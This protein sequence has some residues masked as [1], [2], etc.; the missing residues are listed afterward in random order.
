MVLYKLKSYF[1]KFLNF[2]IIIEKALYTS[3]YLY[4]YIGCIIMEQVYD[5]KWYNELVSDCRE[6]QKE[7]DKSKLSILYL[8]YSMGKRILKDYHRFESYEGGKSQAN[9]AIDLGYKSNATISDMI[10][11][12][13][14][15]DKEFDCEVNKFIDSVNKVP[16]WHE[17]THNLLP[18]EPKEKSINELVEV[19][20][21]FDK[22]KNE[23]EA[24]NFFK[25]L[26]GSY[27]GCFYIGK[28]DKRLWEEASK[29]FGVDMNGT[30][31]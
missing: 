9:L 31:S 11:F 25:L 24:F 27:K 20:I 26:N 13:E 6:I 14:W 22:F 7:T 15:I 8:K 1:F 18:R 2:L 17:V 5:L 29:K 23:D 4:I 28:I 3:Y 12:T 30:P 21:P 19:K 16:S 10:V